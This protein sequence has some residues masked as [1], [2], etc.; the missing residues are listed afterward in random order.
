MSKVYIYDTT[1]RDGSQGEN[2]SF[3]ALEKLRIALE[4][5][6]L[7]V[8]YIEGGFPGSNPKDIEFFELARRETFKTAKLT[9]FGST[10]RC[11]IK[12]ADDPNLK[13][14]LDAN[15]PA[16]A[17]FG[18][19]WDLH[20]TEIIGTTLEENLSMVA[21]SV[22]YLKSK[23]KGVIFDAEHFFDGYKAN[24]EYAFKVLEAA[25]KADADFLALCDTNG[26]T[27]PF[28]VSKIVQDVQAHFTQLGL[29]ANIG[30][31]SH[32]DCG[33]GA[34]DAVAA[35]RMGANM[36]HG[37]INGYGERCGNADL[38]TIIPV[39]SIK[40]DYE[41]IPAEN[42]PFLL[43]TSRYVS[44]MANKVP[45]KA[46][47]FVGKSAF[48]HKGGVHV[49]AVMK[50]PKAYEHMN[51]EL[52]GNERRVLTSDLSG[53]SNITYKAQELGVDLSDSLI[54]TDI[55]QKI[56]KLEQQGYQ[57]DAADGSL[58][59]FM[60]KIIGT[61][62]RPFVLESFRV[63][64]ERNTDRS[65]T[66]HAM[67][68]IHVNNKTEITAAEGDG[69]V[70]ALD[71]A[72][73]KALRRFFPEI[74][75]MQLVDFKVR[76]IEGSEGSGARVR[77]VIESRDKDTIWTTVGVSEDIIEASWQALADSF[78][79]KLAGVTPKAEPECN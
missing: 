31:H 29:N 68:K 1:L 51:P 53:K 62:Q 20:V 33:M 50:N 22:A 72:M 30:I 65:C 57:F 9:A 67:V 8:D 63:S 56:K 54:S 24:P 73:R 55:V 42:L 32:N 48:A 15:T 45:V 64:V 44:E 46:Q 14:L 35:V 18:K 7:G 43:A 25:Q 40:M 16:I 2:I 6:K 36:V 76:V 3:S 77:V 21:D 5:D 60:Q 19:S 10:R 37:T 52:V 78:Y 13:L 4:L 61:F 39:L 58:K 59:I 28:E 49:S 26:G 38:T 69:P 41:T 23:G 66:A 47:P 74:D 11:G 79:C 12:A 70:G 17:I 71:N 34:A 75:E 27:L